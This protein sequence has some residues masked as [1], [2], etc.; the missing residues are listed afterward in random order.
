MARPAPQRWHFAVA[1]AAGFVLLLASTVIVSRQNALSERM[2]VGPALSEFSF[3]EIRFH[4]GALEL[5]GLLFLPAEDGPFPAVVVIHG[6]GTS[7]RNNPWYLSF[8]RA[9]LQNGIAVLLPDKRGSEQSS[10]DWRGVSMEELSTDTEA[11]FRYL[12]SDSRIDPE[13]IGLLGM[14]QGGWIAPIAATNL[15]EAAFVVNISG[16]SVPSEAQLL[17]EEENNLTAMGVPR[18]LARRIAPVS[19][20][21][22]QRRETWQGLSGF[23]PMAYVLQVDQPIFVAYGGGDTNVPVD[24]SVARLRAEAPEV[25]VHVYSNGGHPITDPLSGSIQPELLEDLMTFID[26]SIGR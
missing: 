2:V 24:A 11:A 7:Q 25:E 23:D 21:N 4:N 15:S 6:S 10:G 8:V 22:I 9:F 5:A 20:A 14:S 16:A 12:S 26:G 13:S 3:S 18:W 17:Y 19:S 1:I